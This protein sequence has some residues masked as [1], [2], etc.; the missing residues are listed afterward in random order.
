M[1]GKA[2]RDPQRWAVLPSPPQTEMLPYWGGSGLGSEA[3]VPELR[4]WGEDW[5][6][7]P[8]DSLRGLDRMW[9]ATSKGVWEDAWAHQRS[10]AIIGRCV[11]RWWTHQRSFF[12]RV[13]SQEAGHRLLGL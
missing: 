7:L 10:K 5:G 6:W 12:L 11:R 1:K 13:H 3:R 8:A 4:L 9:C 2:D